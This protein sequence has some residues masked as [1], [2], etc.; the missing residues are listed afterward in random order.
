MSGF[1]T[2]HNFD[3]S[4]DALQESDFLDW[5]EIWRQY[6]E[7]NGGNSVPEQQY[8]NTFS[9]ILAEDGDIHALVVRDPETS[10]IV[11]LS[12]FTILP[13]PWS[14]RSLCHMN[15]MGPFAAVTRRSDAD[16]S[17]AIRL[18]CP[19]VLPK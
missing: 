8:K 14:E 17:R 4:V 7:Y 13:T 1:T 18:I 6:L 15:G 9:R 2:T 3:M 12:H 19:P 5:A 11:G 10:K 16:Q